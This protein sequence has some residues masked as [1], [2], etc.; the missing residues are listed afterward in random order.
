MTRTLLGHMRLRECGAF[1]VLLFLAILGVNVALDDSLA[2]YARLGG[3]AGL[4]G[5]L[6]VHVFLLFRR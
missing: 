3:L 6:A 5:P 4:G 1:V 2:W